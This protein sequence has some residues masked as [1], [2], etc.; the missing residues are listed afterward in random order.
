[1]KL[2]CLLYIEL[3]TESNND[4]GDE[5]EEM[6]DN[7]TIQHIQSTALHYIQSSDGSGTGDAS[8]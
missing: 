1:V 4:N 5:S 7:Y 3:H 8:H 2:G 6:L